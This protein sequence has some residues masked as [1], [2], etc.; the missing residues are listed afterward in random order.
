[1]RKTGGYIDLKGDTTIPIGKYQFYTDTFRTFA[2]AYKNEC[3]FVGIDRKENILFEIYPFDNG[4]DYPKEGL[5]RIIENGKIGYA[6]L[7]GKIVIRPQF[8][9]ALPFNNGRAKVS[10][11]CKTEKNGEHSHWVSEKWYYIDK[12]GQKTN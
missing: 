3:C 11:D 4:P 10:V 9:C 5:F 2:I 7:N 8:D 12:K 6:G 1:M